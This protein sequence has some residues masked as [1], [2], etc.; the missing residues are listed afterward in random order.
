MGGQYGTPTENGNVAFKK[1]EGGPF[2]ADVGYNFY[3]LGGPCL[4]IQTENL[5]DPDNRDNCSPLT[6]TVIGDLV[7]GDVDRNLTQK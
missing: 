4:L 7:T 1:D 3:A 5:Q 2:N 6:K